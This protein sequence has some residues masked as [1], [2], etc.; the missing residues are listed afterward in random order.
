MK[1]A[2]SAVVVALTMAGTAAAQ[3][4]PGDTMRAPMQGPMMRQRMPMMQGQMPQ[5]TP[6]QLRQQVEQRWGN[7]VQQE[8]GL[9]DQQMD[10]VRTSERANQDRQR[11]LGRREED[12]HRAVRDQLQPGVAANNDALNRSLEE[13]AAIRV[14]RAQSDQQLL[15]DIAFLTP[16]QRAR[17]FVMAQRFRERIQALRQG[18]PPAGM[19]PAM[20]PGAQ[21]RQPMR[22]PGIEEFEQL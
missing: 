20:R 2:V 3:N 18:G 9:N 19:A 11:E 12:L 15:R 14:Q 1:H 13:L 6:E 21:P 7:M 4:P 5:R 16:V 8:L 17:Y 10:R 22:R